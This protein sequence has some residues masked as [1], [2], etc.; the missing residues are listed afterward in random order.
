MESHVNGM[1]ATEN[2]SIANGVSTESAALGISG[3]NPPMANGETKENSDSEKESTGDERF[4]VV[5]ESQSTLLLGPDSRTTD[6]TSME[7]KAEE[8]VST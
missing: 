7:I 8:K 3:T 1:A 6:G 2:P 5:S 4:T